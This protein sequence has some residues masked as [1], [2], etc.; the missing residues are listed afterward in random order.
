MKITEAEKVVGL[1]S[2][3]NSIE[4]IERTMEKE[5]RH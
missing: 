3:L 5:E 2:D 4:E 1:M